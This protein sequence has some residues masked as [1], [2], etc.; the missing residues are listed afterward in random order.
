MVGVYELSYETR[1]RRVNGFSRTG[2]GSGGQG[3]Q[4]LLAVAGAVRG[5]LPPPL[6][7]LRFMGIGA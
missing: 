5:G 7:L 6:L 1:R 4:Q 2:R 3:S